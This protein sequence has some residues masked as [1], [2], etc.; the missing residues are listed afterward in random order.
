MPD[1]AV[2]QPSDG[3]P[4]PLLAFVH[5]PKTAGTT[6]R[7][8]L[9]MNEPGRRT[10]ALGNVFKG[11]GGL[12]TALITRL[13]A[14]TLPSLDG[15]S[16]VRGHFPLGIRDHLPTD[17]EVRCFSFL[18]QP[19][20]RTL[21]HYFSIVERPEDGK[22]VSPLPD[23]P[24]LEDALKA[25]YIHDNLHTRMLSGLLKPFDDVTDAMLEQAKH[26]LR[27]ELVFFGLT[28]RFDES[29]VILKHRLGFGRIFYASKDRVNTKRPRAD[30]VPKELLR[31]A[32]RCNRYDLELYRYAEELFDAMPERGEVEFEV[33]LAALRSAKSEENDGFGA[34]V[35]V[36]FDGGEEAWRMLLD[37]RSR[38]L[39]LE[40]EAGKPIPVPVTVQEDA[41]RVEL[42]A[43]R[44]RTR[45][46]ERKLETLEAAPQT[47]GKRREKRAT[48][49]SAAPRTKLE[50][51]SRGP[52]ATR[53]GPKREGRRGGPKAAGEQASGSG[54]QPG[55]T[56]DDQARG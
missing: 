18:R 11:G 14:G 49:K 45:E 6:L 34:G 15:V 8:I 23:D 46:L 26:N 48:P 44:A 51:G 25:G 56:P 52:K 12:S 2:H 13:R 7:A 53:T 16:V 35:P 1:T 33:D 21:S 19:V 10:I 43:A 29:L 31:A 42:E 55:R 36:A 9:S 39:R 47:R 27:E 30:E 32:E 22:G 38:V 17:R 4:P 50:G 5:V 3:G 28:E 24:T 40:C 20:D 54:K 41:L 37:A